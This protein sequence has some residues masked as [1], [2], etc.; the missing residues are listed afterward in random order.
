MSISKIKKM[1]ILAAIF[2]LINLFINYNGMSVFAATGTDA[3]GF[4][5]QSDEG[6][7]CS[8]IGYSG[9]LT[10][11]IIPST[12]DG[13]MVTGI[14]NYAFFQN[15]SITSVVIPN[16][17]I[18]IGEHAFDNCSS[19]T[20][21]NIPNGV[22][23]IGAGTFNQCKALLSIIIPGTVT[24]IGD[25]AFFE[26]LKITNVTIPNGVTSIGESA[27][28]S[29]R[30]LQSVYMPDSVTSVGK[31]T[32]NDCFALSSIRL[33]NNL[34]T[35]VDQMFCRNWALT[36]ITLPSGITSIGIKA[37]EECGLTKITIPNSVTNIGGRAFLMCQSLSN[38][39]IPNNVK[40][41]GFNAFAHCY[42]FTNIVIPN[43]VSSIGDYA[44]YTC[45]NLTEIT[46]PK[47]VSS[48]GIYA[49]SSCNSNL[50]ITGFSSSYA[51]VYA[52]NNKI[53]FQMI[54]TNEGSNNNSTQTPPA[55]NQGSNPPV[56]NQGSNPLAQNQGTKP[57]A[58]SQVT[59]PN[60]A[61]PE[62]PKIED[63]KLSETS[64][65]VS[66][67]TINLK[68]GNK[69][70]LAVTVLPTDISNKIVTWSTSNESIAVVDNIGVI[71]AKGIGI[72]T[73]TATV[74]T[75]SSTCV[76]IVANNLVSLNG[77][78]KKISIAADQSV[79][80]N[81][82]NLSVSG[83][84][85]KK[86]GLNSK[87]IKKYSV[88]N[89]FDFKLEDTNGKEVEP[90]DYVMV[91]IPLSPSMLKN[92]GSYLMIYIDDSGTAHEI[93]STIDGSNLNFTTDHFSRYAIVTKITDNPK[94]GDNDLKTIFISIAIILSAI[95]G[96]LIFLKQKGVLA[97]KR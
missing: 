73:I 38:V 89:C 44:F 39:T 6:T 82:V 53:T 72:T 29:C 40:T 75:K 61:K 96:V 3:N 27:F 52:Q 28:A 16:S 74:G 17:V 18:S 23:R 4:K 45:K 67:T 1:V 41:I 92:A 80:N 9:S 35:I 42:A 20:N 11:I 26:C 24:S 31:Y 21:I 90:T 47:S 63:S 85:Y 95:I 8:I 83:V 94:Q 10:N 54:P 62:S 56:Q 5:W 76:V 78:A 79:L 70:A 30:L 81:A 91:T 68:V 77:N 25:Y 12:I 71:T 86:I 69:Q 55:Q 15:R 36:N 84:D 66:P 50:I 58:Q 22:T 87:Y 48:I 49:L 32:F 65:S 34:T 43:S 57:I 93:K 97:N 64:I 7:T 33:S 51:Q 60:T 88:V 46:I 59:N 19:L 2:V 37:F 13:K 14:G